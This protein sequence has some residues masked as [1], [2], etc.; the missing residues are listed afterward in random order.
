MCVCVCWPVS[1]AD[2]WFCVCS[3]CVCVLCMTCVCG[4]VRVCVSRLTEEKK[5]LNSE[6][7]TIRAKLKKREREGRHG[8]EETRDEEEMHMRKEGKAG[9]D[10]AALS[11]C[12][13]CVYV[14]VREVK[15]AT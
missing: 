13:V 5:G 2:G 12:G 9:Q 15:P 11:P 8:R 1:S 6:T 14:C 7:E 10:N 3:T 4:C